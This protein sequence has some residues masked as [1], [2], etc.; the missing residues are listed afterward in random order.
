M[1]AYENKTHLGVV[2]LQI[3]ARLIVVADVP[4]IYNNTDIDNVLSK[5][6]GSEDNRN[7]HKNRQISGETTLCVD[8]YI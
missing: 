2:G 1:Y 7:V 5:H 8:K 4:F 3:L 6:H